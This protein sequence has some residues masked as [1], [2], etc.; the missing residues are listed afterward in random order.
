MLVLKA[1]EWLRSGHDVHVLSTWAESL[2]ASS[3]IVA[4]LKQ[5]EPK[6]RDRLAYMNCDLV[7]ATS[8]KLGSSTI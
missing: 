6:A 1:L 2:S 7:K 5:T 3:F 4:Q 8:S